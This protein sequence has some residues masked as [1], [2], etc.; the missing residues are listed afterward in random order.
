MFKNPCACEHCG[1]ERNLPRC[2]FDHDLMRCCAECDVRALHEFTNDEI[3]AC[4]LRKEDHGML[5][6]NALR[7]DSDI[8]LELDHSSLQ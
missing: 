1:D 6:G 5:S 8:F 2:V 7:D 3:R 4:A